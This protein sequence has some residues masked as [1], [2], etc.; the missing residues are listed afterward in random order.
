MKPTS[1][2]ER[3][4]CH[5][6]ARRYESGHRQRNAIEHISPSKIDPIDRYRLPKEMCA[7]YSLPTAHAKP[8]EDSC[9]RSV[10]TTR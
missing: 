6:R 7:F 10:W 3:S 1:T 5:S 8:M 4:L 9:R 2:S